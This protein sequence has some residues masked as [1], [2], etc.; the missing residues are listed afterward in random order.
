MANISA[1]MDSTVLCCRPDKCVISSVDYPLLFLSDCLLKSQLCAV[2]GPVSSYMIAH[3]LPWQAPCL[4]WTRHITA[5]PLTML[6]GMYIL[7]A[8]AVNLSIKH[9]NLDYFLPYT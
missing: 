1:D 9:W 4:S 6:N 5:K 8:S 3:L 2:E 7:R